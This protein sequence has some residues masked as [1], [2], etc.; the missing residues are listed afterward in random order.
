MNYH[1]AIENARKELDGTTEKYEAFQALVN[2]WL[3]A[4]GV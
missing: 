3:A 1:T 2:E 4:E